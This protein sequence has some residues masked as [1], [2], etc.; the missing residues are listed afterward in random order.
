M[1]YVN[2]LGSIIHVATHEYYGMANKNVGDA[3]LL[4]W[5]ICEGLLRGYCDADSI[6]NEETRV[7][8]VREVCCPPSMGAGH[9]KR[10]L[11]PSE[12]ADSAL[13]AFLRIMIDLENAN[14]DGS[15]TEYASYP[16]I[17]KRFGTG[18]RVRVHSV[19][20]G[21]CCWVAFIDLLPLFSDQ[22]G[23]WFARRMGDRRGHRVFVQD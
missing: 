10:E 22:N 12:M 19:S 23:V 3:F 2:K 14:T 11:S 1:V 4:S 9:M 18:F 15:L 16:R 13:T 17:I 5:K 20:P 7:A 6:P 8:A 21:C